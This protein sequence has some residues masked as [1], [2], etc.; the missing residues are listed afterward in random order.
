MPNSFRRTCLYGFFCE[1]KRRK[2][3]RVARHALLGLIYAGLGRCDEAKAEAK[4]AIDLLPESKDAFDGPILTS[5]RARIHLMCAD[6]D[7]TFAL[8]ERSLPAPAGITVPEL[9][10][11]PVWDGLP[12]DPRLQ[13]LLAKYGAEK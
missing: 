11:D 8:I 6:L 5:S 3:Y 13:P 7:A 12:A 9:R 10:L 1:L 2:V 4:R